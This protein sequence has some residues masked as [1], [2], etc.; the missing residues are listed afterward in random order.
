MR[1]L[2]ITE[3]IMQ[4]EFYSPWQQKYMYIQGYSSREKV[5]ST[6]TN[7]YLIIAYP[8]VIQVNICCSYIHWTH[9]LSFEQLPLHSVFLTVIKLKIHSSQAHI[10]T[11]YFS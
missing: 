5:F 1:S 8:Y 2:L 11:V 3:C 10:T 9:I 4:A 7:Y 6:N